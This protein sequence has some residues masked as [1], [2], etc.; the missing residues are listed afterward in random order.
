MNGTEDCRKQ[1]ITVP[2]N[3]SKPKP[4]PFVKCF[5][6]HPNPP[7]CDCRLCVFNKEFCQAK[8]TSEEDAA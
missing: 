6:V 2:E 7:E 8:Q 4:N 1:G 5:A 3:C